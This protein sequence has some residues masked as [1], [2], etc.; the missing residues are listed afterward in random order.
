MNEIIVLD[1][2]TKNI[3]NQEEIAEPLANHFCKISFLTSNTNSNYPDHGSTDLEINV[4]PYDVP[5]TMNLK[6]MK[7]GAT[8]PNKIY[9]DIVK[10]LTESA[11]YTI[12]CSFNKI[13]KIIPKTWSKTY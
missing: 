6:S 7:S 4:P 8:D 1:S 9:I 3:T 10:N 13:W 2:N 11:V 5:M 12:L